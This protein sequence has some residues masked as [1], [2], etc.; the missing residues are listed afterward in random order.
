MDPVGNYGKGPDYVYKQML[1]S[2]C[3]KVILKMY[4]G[5]RHELFNETNREEVYSDLLKWIKSV[6]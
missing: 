1:V 4:K 3:E 2:G 5:A 6:I